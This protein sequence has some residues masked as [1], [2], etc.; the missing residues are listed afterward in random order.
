MT[1]DAGTGQGAE[2]PVARVDRTLEALIPRFMQRRRD[3]ADT[4]ESL[5]SQGDFDAIQSIGHSIKGSGGGYGFDPVTEYGS[6]IEVAARACD[7]P[8]V[9]AAARQMRAYMDAV[10]IEFVDE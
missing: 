9:I 3:D 2:R 6:T 4:I 7:G 1:E 5:V 8:G 10:D